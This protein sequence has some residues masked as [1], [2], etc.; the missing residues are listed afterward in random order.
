MSSDPPII[1]LKPREGRR[2]RAGAPWV[3]SN[4]IVMDGKAKALDRKSVV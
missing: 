2:V 1:R 4:E 3:F